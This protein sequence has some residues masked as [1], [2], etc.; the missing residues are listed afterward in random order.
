M[1][2]AVAPFAIAPLCTPLLAVNIF[3]MYIYT[4]QRKSK[5]KNKNDIDKVPCLFVQNLF[6]LSVGYTVVPKLV[7]H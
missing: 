6:L 7:P 4:R 1:P 2:G 3:G 5:V